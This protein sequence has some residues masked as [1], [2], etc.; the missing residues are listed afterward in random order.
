LPRDPHYSHSPN[1]SVTTLGNRCEGKGAVEYQI[2]VDG[3]NP[4]LYNV[5]FEIPGAFTDFTLRH[6][7]ANYINP[8]R[9]SGFP[10]MVIG[11]NSV[12]GEFVVAYREVCM[13]TQSGYYFPPEW[14]PE[15]YYGAEVQILVDEEPLPA[16]YIPENRWQ[17][18]PRYDSEGNAV[19]PS[20]WAYCVPANWSRGLHTMTINVTTTDGTEHT[21]SWQFRVE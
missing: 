17:L 19:Q 10:L 8:I 16:A 3:S 20:F 13:E 18:T 21:F 14:F 11:M 6:G 15:E 1:T 4:H 9:G 12:G 7:S 5:R 2:A